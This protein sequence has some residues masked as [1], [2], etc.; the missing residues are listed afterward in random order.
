MFQSADL[1]KTPLRM[2]IY[3]PAGCGK[4]LTSLLIA[5]EIVGPKG[6]IAVLDT[7]HGS[8]TKH[9]RKV[10]F[11]VEMLTG[12]FHPAKYIEIIHAAEKT[13]DIL[14]IDSLTHGWA[15]KNGVL[16]IVDQAT[17]RSRSKNS[18]TD[19]WSIGTPLHQDL[20]EAILGCKIHVIATMR[21]KQEYALQ[22][23][24]QGK[25]APVKLGLA[26]IQ[27]AEVD[28]EFDI[29]G[30]MDAQHVL[31]I[32]KE[33]YE[34]LAGKSFVKPGADLGRIIRQFLDEG[35]PGELP[36]VEPL[37]A[38]IERLRVLRDAER[39]GLGEP[40]SFSWNAKQGAAPL[41]EEIEAS[42]DRIIQ[43]IVAAG[44]GS[45]EALEVLTDDDLIANLVVLSV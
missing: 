6:K 38:L 14:I 3:G 39:Q 36:S 20:I 2:A 16:Q 41:V 5:R 33:R 10:R 9:A 40:P 34:P 24:D 18:F 7:E 37:T 26:P 28:Y 42:R 35:V 44:G 1:I 45:R 4:S 32:E 22:T 31:E 21:S 11:D 8:S 13:H 30:R 27:R 15:G 19:G 43:A 29:V 17:A 25:I 12:N 23:N